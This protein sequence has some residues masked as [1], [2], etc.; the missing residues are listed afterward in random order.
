MWHS[1]LTESLFKLGV[2]PSINP[3]CKSCFFVQAARKHNY[4]GII[5]TLNG[6]SPFKNIIAKNL[7][8]HS[9]GV[10]VAIKRDRGV[11]VGRVYLTHRRLERNVRG[12][13]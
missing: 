13:Q 3:S 4:S 2:P 11:I 7:P 8:G 10:Y 1:L 6:G 5:S 9:R 12:E